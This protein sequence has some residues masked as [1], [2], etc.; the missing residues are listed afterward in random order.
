MRDGLVRT[1]SGA[2]RSIGDF[3]QPEGYHRMA[4]Q[5]LQQDKAK[6]EKL[7]PQPPKPGESLL[8]MTLPGGKTYEERRSRGKGKRN[9][10]K[11]YK[12]ALIGLTVVAG[13]ALLVGGF[14]GVKTYMKVHKVFKGGGNAV[15]LQQNVAPSL[16]KGEGDGRINILLLGKGGE[17]HDGADLT[18][19]MLLMSVD[20][21]NKKASLVSVPRD[22][23]VQVPGDGHT[24]INAVYATA[25]SRAL[26]S[27]PKDK[28]AAEKAGVQAAEKVVADI[29][30]VNIHYYAMVDFQAFKQ[31]VD[32]VGGVDI[33]VP[34]DLVDST[35]AWENKWNPVLAKKGL[36]HMDGYRALMYVR[37]RHGSAR[38][39][40]DRAERQRLLIAA[41]AQK[42][43]N[44][45]TYT[46]PVKD[47]QLLDA[48]GDHVS[49]DMSVGDAIRL[50]KIMKGMASTGIESIGLSDEPNNFLK[51]GMV[52]SASVVMPVAGIDNY[53]AIRAFIRTKLKDGYITKENAKITVL[54]G[55]GIAGLATQKAD[56]LKSYGYNVLAVGDAPTT[57]YQKTVIVDLTKG[58][59]PYTKNYLEKR[60]DVKSTTKLS[61]ST[62][63][64]NAADFIIIVGTDETASSQN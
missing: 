14:L 6:M 40:F 45:G 17:G 22:L 50:V 1:N 23:W 39:D 11:T 8:N 51:T 49:T 3:R 52:G 27:N 19:T 62:I 61:D 47:S 15:S 60:F 59:K 18:D 56:I 48:F 21:V 5:H 55:S 46:N 31:A 63:Q 24:K 29:L 43:L 10:R 33:H 25:K 37:S 32:A 44:A 20:P 41:L 12:R 58:K 16:L 9:W 13:I 53:D 57:N 7:P 35:M 54:N 28:K 36:Q 42:I 2:A 4:E 26:Y 64:T 38:G 34:E 30:G